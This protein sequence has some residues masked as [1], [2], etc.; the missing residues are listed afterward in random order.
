MQRARVRVE[1]KDWDAL[2]L[3]MRAKK[4]LYITEGIVE[5]EAQERL[6]RLDD[7]KRVATIVG[8]L[9][10]MM[11]ARVLSVGDK[12][13]RTTL[14]REVKRRDIARDRFEEIKRQKRS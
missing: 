8:P 13:N 3:E 7:I 11:H 10:A 1:G 5:Q 12:L 6:Q 4:E 9:V 2:V 14:S